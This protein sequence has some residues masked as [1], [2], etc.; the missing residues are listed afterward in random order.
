MSQDEQFPGLVCGCGSEEFERVVIEREGLP[1][2][3]TVLAECL[4]CHAAFV[5]PPVKPSVQERNARVIQDV[6]DAAKGYRKPSRPWRE[7]DPRGREKP[8]SK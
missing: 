7:G 6:R 3:R 2:H 5:A 4:H 1:P 8:G